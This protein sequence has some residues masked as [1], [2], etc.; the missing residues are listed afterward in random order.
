MKLAL[1]QP[2]FFPYIGYWQ[3]L[4]HADTFILFDD[5]QYSNRGWVNRNRILK[6]TEDWQYVTVPL[7][8]HSQ[9]SK[10]KDIKT[11]TNDDWKNKICNQLSHYKKTA[12]YY[13]MTFEMI[14]EALYGEAS[15]KISQ[16]NFFILKFLSRQ[17]GMSKEFLVSSEMGFDYSNVSEPGEWALRIS[18]QT[19]A[20]EY[21]NPASGAA[22]Y[23]LKKFSNSN[24]KL[25]FLK[26]MNIVYDQH[27]SFI[28][29]LS[30]IDVLMFNSLEETKKLLQHY[31]MVKPVIAHVYS[32]ISKC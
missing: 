9:K 26:P 6:P 4:Y 14:R 12:P 5:V 32:K 17:F 7:E 11:L 30:I 20:S 24:I 19:S 8:K 10:I 25:K 23:S 22:L 27:R 1:M 28:P 2:Y 21:V 15:Q 29:W 18:E 31:E 3:L 13:Q 16:I